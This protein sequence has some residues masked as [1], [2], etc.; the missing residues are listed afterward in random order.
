MPGITINTAEVSTVAHVIRNKDALISRIRRIK[1]QAESIERAVRE[2]QACSVVLQQIA[3]CRGAMNGLMYE[4]I[5]DH[6][7][8]HII[9]PRR[10][11]TA[12]QAEAAEE[13]IDVLKTYL[14]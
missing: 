12:Q 2:G 3:A 10:K 14:K 7:R 13:V 5:E 6:I 11:P 8:E 9:D 4:V 1:G